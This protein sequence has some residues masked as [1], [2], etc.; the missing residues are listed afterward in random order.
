MWKYVWEPNP[1]DKSIPLLKTLPERFVANGGLADLGGWSI[2]TARIPHEELIRDKKDG[3]N[4]DHRMFY[5]C[6]HC[7]GWIEGHPYEY[8]ENTIGPLSGRDGTVSSCIRCG[9]EI[10]FSGAVS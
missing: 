10:G 9:N 8:H 1:S 6:T 4:V 5:Y 3:K 7:E 2:K